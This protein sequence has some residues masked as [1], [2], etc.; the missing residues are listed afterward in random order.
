MI[1]GVTGSTREPGGYRSTVA[2]GGNRGAGER[3]V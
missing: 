2:P 1:G 3:G